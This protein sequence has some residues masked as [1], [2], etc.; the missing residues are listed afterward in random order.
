MQ[1][2]AWQTT[3]SIYILDKTSK[4][5]YI[6]AKSIYI[7]DQPIANRNYKSNLKASDT[8]FGMTIRARDTKRSVGSSMLQT[9]YIASRSS[10]YCRQVKFVTFLNQTTISLQA[11]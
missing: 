1:K 8:K 4:S 6:L 7:L 9:A 3:K 5:I 11:R 10:F 2:G